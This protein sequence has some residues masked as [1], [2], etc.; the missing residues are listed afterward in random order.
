M[1][2]EL[3]RGTALR[4]NW[5]TNPS[6]SMPIALNTTLTYLADCQFGQLHDLHLAAQTLEGQ[7]TSSLALVS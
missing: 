6:I 5:A 2:R 4:L 3:K 7:S 1:A